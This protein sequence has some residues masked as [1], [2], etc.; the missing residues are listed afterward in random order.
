MSKL[1]FLMYIPCC[2]LSFRTSSDI[3]I[4]R[5]LMFFGDATEKQAAMAIAERPTSLVPLLKG[6]QIPCLLRDINLHEAE[7]VICKW[8]EEL[9][10]QY[11]KQ[12]E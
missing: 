6:F 9:D 7:D 1:Q 10:C 12:D 2:F 11:Q 3:P 8:D 5:S 4:F